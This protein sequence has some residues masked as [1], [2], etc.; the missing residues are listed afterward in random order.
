MDVAWA[1]CPSD[2]SPEKGLKRPGRILP[3]CARPCAATFQQAAAGPLRRRLG[4]QLRPPPPQSHP[5]SGVKPDS[6]GRTSAPGSKRNRRGRRETCDGSPRRP[7]VANRELRSR[8]RVTPTELRRGGAAEPTEDGEEQEEGVA[9]TD[10]SST[11]RRRLRTLLAGEINRDCAVGRM[12]TA[13]TSLALYVLFV[14]AQR[15]NPTCGSTNTSRAS[16]L[17]CPC[18][19]GNRS[20]SGRRRTNRGSKERGERPEESQGTVGAGSVITCLPRQTKECASSKL[21]AACPSGCEDL[22]AV[23]E[24]TG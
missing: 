20:S 8:A 3:S 16:R 15:P 10:L 2:P 11:L 7:C 14:R 17:A 9:P 19:T 6:G 18:R 5:A 13:C 21:A 23:C 22:R 4:S 12:P 1:H 24:M